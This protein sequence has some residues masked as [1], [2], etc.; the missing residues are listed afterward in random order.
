MSDRH[1]ADQHGT[2]AKRPWLT[3][4]GWRSVILTWAFLSAF[5]T[6][7]NIANGEPWGVRATL[8]AV[9]FAWWSTT[10]ELHAFYERSVR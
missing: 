9:L 8:T 3:R 6:L 10:R 7:A 2:T 4:D 1:P 5:F